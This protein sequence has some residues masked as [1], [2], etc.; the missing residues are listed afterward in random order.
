MQRPAA[1]SPSTAKQLRRFRLHARATGY[2][3]PVLPTCCQHALSCCESFDASRR[4]HA[5]YKWGKALNAAPDGESW[6]KIASHAIGQ[7]NGE[8]YSAALSRAYFSSRAV[9]CKFVL[10]NLAV[11][12]R[13]IR[14][15][16][17]RFTS[18]AIFSPH[19]AYCRG[20]CQRSRGGFRVPRVK[21]I[22]LALGASIIKDTLFPARFGKTVTIR[23]W[24]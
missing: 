9:F 21:S 5:A 23:V 15:E 1:A 2:H 19:P 6:R 12:S 11:C 13:T 14:C 7:R 4:Q 16:S 20:R 3:D 17:R 18:F 24:R 22:H 8:Q 10:A